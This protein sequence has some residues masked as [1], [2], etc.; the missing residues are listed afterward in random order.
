M[1][2]PVSTYRSASP[3]VE[4]PEAHLR[5][6][7]RFVDA[8]GP[9]HREA[10]QDLVRAPGERHQ[11]LHRVGL[12]AGLPEH[13]V[14][15]HHHGVS[16]DDQGPG[17]ER[18]DVGR[19]LS[20]EPEHVRSRLLTLEE[21]LVDV[22]RMDFGAQPELPED[23]EAPGGRGSEDEPGRAHRSSMSVTGPSLTSSTSIMAPNSP[24]STFATLVRSMRRRSARRGGSPGPERRR[25][26]ART[27]A[28]A[29][30]PVEGEL[31]DDEKLPVDLVERAVHAPFVVREDAQPDDLVGHPLDLR[32]A[33][34]FGEADQQQVP[35]SD[36]PDGGPF[37]AHLGA[38][39][40]LEQDPHSTVTD[41]ARLRGWS[42]S[43]PFSTAMW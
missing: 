15:A 23:V 1:G 7:E 12:V 5:A 8:A 38:G 4:V 19:L 3:P 40:P 10:A 25:H 16:R 41:L 39:H 17:N 27:A 13:G 18:R 26:E 35:P 36:R 33:V 34:T 9:R 2:S 14:V 32:V 21:A 30:I 42:T 6:R 29:G 20:G 24:V 22:R 43:A 28:L 31:T 11:H 37:D